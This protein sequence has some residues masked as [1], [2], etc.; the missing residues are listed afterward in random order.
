MIEEAEDMRRK[1]PGLFRHIWLGECRTADENALWKQSTMI[2]PYRVHVCGVDLERIVIGV[3]PAVTSASSSDLTGIVAAGRAKNQKTGEMEYYVL[4]DRSL[5][6][7]PNEWAQAVI[8]LYMDYDADRVVGEVN[9]GGDLIESLLR[10]FD[11]TVSFMAV[12]A[13]RGKILRA[14]P[15]AALYERGLVHH[16]GDFPQLEDE[17]CSF[18]GADGEKSPDRLDALVWALTEL[19]GGVSAE[20][21]QGE[22]ALSY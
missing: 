20:P 18:V 22:I 16:V 15:I 1:N 4:E 14:E 2:E 10:R 17:M 7:T 6:A 19:S 5:R 9:N 13:T 11:P 3:D 12:R 8:D 21:E